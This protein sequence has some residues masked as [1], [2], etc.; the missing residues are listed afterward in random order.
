VSPAV[1]AWQRTYLT[2][3]AGI[4]GFAL[5]YV[6]CDYAEWP[7]LT[8]FPYERTWAFV[9]RSP[10]PVPANYV[11]T[12]LW[13]MG[14]ALVGSGCAYLLLGLGRRGWPDRWLRLAGGWAV[15]A[16]LYAGLYFTWN[17]WPF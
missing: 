12:I 4:I 15:A 10:S 14:G 9:T 8:Y 2:A 6:L 16:F 1:P 13:G 17:L 11:G 7:R 3:C 5:A